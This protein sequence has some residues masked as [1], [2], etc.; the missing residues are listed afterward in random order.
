MNRLNL[1]ALLGLCCGLACDPLPMTPPAPTT[2]RDTERATAGRPDFSQIAAG[3]RDASVTYYLRSGDGGISHV[4]YWDI[5]VGSS[6][7]QALP[8]MEQAKLRKLQS[9]V[10]HSARIKPTH[11]VPGLEVTGTLQVTSDRG[12]RTQEI[13]LKIPASWNGDLVVAGTPGTRNELAS[14]GVF[15]SWLVAKG[16]AFVA[17][18]KGMT[19][20]GVDGNATL[21]S[22]QHPTQHWGMM[23]L[24]L[25]DWAVARLK[26]ASGQHPGRVYAVGISNGGYQVRRALELDHVRVQ[27]GEARRFDGGIDWAGAYWPDRS[28]LDGNGDGV[29]S[30]A[31]FAAKNHLISQNERAMLAMGYAY[32]AGSNTTPDEFAKVPPYPKA[33]DAMQAAGFDAASALIWGAYNTAFDAVKAA[34]PDWRGVGYYNFTGYY[35]RAELLGHTAKE[36]AAYTP[37]AKMGTPPYYDYLR[38]S[39]DGGWD[40][41]S[42]GWALANANSAAFSAPLISLH[43]D[44]DGLLGLQAHALA[45]RAAIKRVGQPALHRLYVVENG[46]HIDAHSDGKLDFDFDGQIGEE[47]MAD[48]FTYMQPYVERAFDYLRDWVLRAEAPPQSGTLAT[49]AS[50]D[51][52]SGQGLRFVPRSLR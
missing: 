22:G 6:A 23:M 25:A 30:P 51:V 5:A 21:L 33:Q 3:L 34:L 11:E 37:F 26:A 16:F 46:G 49:D 19:N 20:G 13:V 8:S 35:F 39:V 4:T 41:Q 52:L 36:S 47:G 17:G 2:T 12:S 7:Y 38:R 42:V 27:A 10:L 40:A 32:E 29:V 9:S 43:G 31:E 44:R 50:Q 48:R 14:D 15:A 45:Y 18:N 24:D 28:A 1:F